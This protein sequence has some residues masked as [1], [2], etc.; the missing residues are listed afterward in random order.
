[1]KKWIL[2][3]LTV[4]LALVGMSFLTPPAQEAVEQPSVL[5]LKWV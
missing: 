3:A 2:S 4:S 1:M 5:T